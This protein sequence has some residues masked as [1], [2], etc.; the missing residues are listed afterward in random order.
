MSSKCQFDTNG[1]RGLR[2]AETARRKVREV[3]S[4]QC[5]ALGQRR[6]RSDDRSRHR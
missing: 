5:R 4:Q 1:V 3:V 2:L 6:V